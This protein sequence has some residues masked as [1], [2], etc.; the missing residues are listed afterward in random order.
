MT[1]C[2]LID[3]RSIGE[4]YGITQTRQICRLY[5]IPR[6][7]P[8]GINLPETR[9]LHSLSFHVLTGEDQLRDIYYLQNVEAK[10]EAVI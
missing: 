1:V 5:N 3:P 7:W 8:N 10:K 2:G 4:R 9:I 6:F